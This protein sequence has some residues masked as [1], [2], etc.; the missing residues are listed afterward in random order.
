MRSCLLL[1]VSNVVTNAGARSRKDS[2]PPTDPHPSLSQKPEEVDEAV[3]T[4]PLTIA[5]RAAA[6]KAKADAKKK[7][8]E[9]AEKGRRKSKLIKLGR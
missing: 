2:Q 7:E 4:K 3:A 9:E 8:E 1:A 5:E 6:E